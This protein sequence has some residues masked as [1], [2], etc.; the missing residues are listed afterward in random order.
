MELSQTARL[1]S[2][3][4][5]GGAEAS[6]KGKSALGKNTGSSTLGTRPGRASNSVVGFG[7]TDVSGRSVS[8]GEES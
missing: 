6:S 4:G 5:G 1:L 7:K 2:D 3:G 8:A